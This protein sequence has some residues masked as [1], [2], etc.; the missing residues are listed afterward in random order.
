MHPKQGKQMKDDER[1]FWDINLMFLLFFD[2]VRPSF[3]FCY[4]DPSFN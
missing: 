3:I 2:N 1:F 4:D